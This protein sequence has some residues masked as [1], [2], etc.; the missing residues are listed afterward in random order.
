MPPLEQRRRLLRASRLATKATRLTPRPPLLLWTATP[1]PGKAQ[2]AFSDSALISLRS[3]SRNVYLSP[4]LVWLE[5]EG[6][7]AAEREAKPWRSPTYINYSWEEMEV[8]KMDEEELERRALL[9]WK[10]MGSEEKAVWRK[11]A[12][13]KANKKI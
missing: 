3:R 7:A 2:L 13:E 6:L 8:E 1:T 4:A 5:E 9:K 10:M 11:R 12:E